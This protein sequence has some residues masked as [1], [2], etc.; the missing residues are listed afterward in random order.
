LGRR[1]F[2]NDHDHR[3]YVLDVGSLRVQV[4]D[5]DGV[6]VGASI[7]GAIIIV[8]LGDNDPVGNS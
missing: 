4:C 7:D 6:G 2:Q 1:G 8:V 5:Q 3:S